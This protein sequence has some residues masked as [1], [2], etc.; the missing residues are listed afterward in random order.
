M[1][2]PNTRN[3][4]VFFSFL[5]DRST[6]TCV[7][8]QSSRPFFFFF[9]SNS[10]HVLCWYWLYWYWLYVGIGCIGSYCNLTVCLYTD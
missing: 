10:H 1:S 3:V 6:I 4:L 5:F 2:V 9:F 8:S 7:Q